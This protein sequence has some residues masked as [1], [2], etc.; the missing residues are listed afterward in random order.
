MAL[1]ELVSSVDIHHQ[2]ERLC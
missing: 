2:F 1:P